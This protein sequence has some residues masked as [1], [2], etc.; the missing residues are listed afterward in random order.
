M[1]A[2]RR[3]AIAIIDEGEAGTA[4]E[5]QQQQQQPA[6]PAAPEGDEIQAVE[7]GAEASRAKDAQELSQN[8]AEVATEGM[9]IAQQ[10][11]VD[12][13]VPPTPQPGNIEPATE[14]MEQAANV[15]AS[16]EAAEPVAIAIAAAAAAAAIPPIPT[17][18]NSE[19]ATEGMSDAVAPQEANP[20]TQPM[21]VKQEPATE[22][23]SPSEV[24]A[25]IPPIPEPGNEE[26]A[27]EGM[28]AA[29]AAHQEAAPSPAEVA[30]KQPPSPVEGNL[31]PATEGMQVDGTDEKGVAGAS[32]A[33][34][35]THTA[36]GDV[37]MTSDS[38][39]VREGVAGSLPTAEN[40]VPESANRE[41]GSL[42]PAP[43][44]KTLA[45]V[46]GP[47]TKIY[48]G[49][50]PAKTTR[51]DLEDCFGQFGRIDHLELKTGYAFIV[52]WCLPLL[53][54]CHI[55]T[56]FSIDALRLLRSCKRCQA[57]PAAAHNEACTRLT[58]G[59]TLLPSILFLHDR[60]YTA[61]D[62]RS[63]ATAS[64]TR[65]TMRTPVYCAAYR[66]CI[67]DHAIKFLGVRKARRCRRG[68]RDV[69]WWSFSGGGV[70][71]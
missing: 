33:N 47:R 9:N 64:M 35:E 48:I 55:Q 53:H 26:P 59:L 23:M 61:C 57:V 45:D 30:P 69:Q 2:T 68:Y 71:S 38:G 19:P 49:G 4:V 17:P 29:A 65:M 16:S 70:E 36:P 31:E 25:V 21:A 7:G 8:N 60:R 41:T 56:G 1:V 42:P 58:M 6:T 62:L 52:S 43:A 12:A 32:A 15:S 37:S 10:V 13:V 11:D 50:L 22:G 18:G 66:F 39:E 44:S 67:T 20:S 40:G 63:S 3:S 34:G 14:G 46:E 51:D 28:A 24:S 27:T 5:Q 54:A